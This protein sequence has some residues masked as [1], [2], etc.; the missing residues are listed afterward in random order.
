MKYRRLGGAGVKVSEISLG[1]WISCDDLN[2]K[3]D[4]FRIIEKAYECGINF[5]DSANVYSQGRAEIIL[6]EAL[7]KFPRETC[8]IATKVYWP[9]G[10]GPNQRGLSRKHIME[11]SEKSLKR[12]GTDYID[13][14]YCHWFDH[15]VPVEETLRAMDDLIRRGMILYFGVSNWTAAQISEGLRVCD[16]FLL[17][18]M[19]AN[20]PSYNMFDRYIEKETIPLCMKNGIGQ[21][22]YS[23]LAQGTLTGKYRRGTEYAAGS[24][25]ANRN[26]KAEVTVWDYLN[27]EILGQ[28]EKLTQIA[29]E[30]GVRLSQLALAWIL[31]QTNVA[32]ALTGASRPSQVEENVK[33]SDISLSDGLLSRIGEVLDSGAYTVKHNI[34]LE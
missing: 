25:A 2:A 34:V 27:D 10:E 28:V 31:R 33:A 23:P 1:S 13:L 11:E 8:V 29:D 24:R 6:G 26:I 32:S 14:Y 22:V 16:R 5:F 19:V 7:R 17:D 21:V 18:R 12:L 3:E 9:M 15:E 4:S 20:Q 30:A